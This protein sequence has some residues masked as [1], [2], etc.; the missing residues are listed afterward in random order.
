MA[1]AEYV[2]CLSNCA[3]NTHHA[4][5]RPL[6]RSYLAASARLLALYV[7]AANDEQCQS[8]ISEYERLWGQ[9]WLV[10]PEHIEIGAAWR[11]FKATT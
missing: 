4:D 5:D 2:L 6:Y 11:Q 7:T 3:E 1:L 10:G 9:T 8:A